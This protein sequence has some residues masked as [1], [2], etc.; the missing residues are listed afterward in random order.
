MKSNLKGF[1]LRNKDEKFFGYLHRVK[2]ATLLQIN[3]DVYDFDKFRNVYQRIATLE[4]A[5]LLTQTSH[6]A[7]PKQKLITLSRKG[8]DEFVSTGDERIVELRSDSIAHDV[9]LVDIRHRFLNSDKVI[10]YHTENTLQTWLECLNSK[11]LRPYVE[12]RC[13]AAIK[14]RFPTGEVFLAVEYEASQ[15][16][17]SRIREAIN[18]YYN[19]DEIPAVLYICADDDIIQRYT[20]EERR[21]F[22]KYDARIYYKTIESFTH[23]QTLAFKNRDGELLRLGKKVGE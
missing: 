11:E 12:A 14:A 20:Q 16:F 2:I 3:R 23:D 18:K 7:F 22:A 5:G 6:V 19:T 13:D 17:A 21:N 9:K 1:W 15:K 10:E 8:F 4:K